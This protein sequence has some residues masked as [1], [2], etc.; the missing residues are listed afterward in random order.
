MEEKDLIEIEDHENKRS[1]HN[2]DNRRKFY[3]R[4]LLSAY[5][6]GKQGV[7][8]SHVPGMEDT[9]RLTAGELEA[10]YRFVYRLQGNQALLGSAQDSKH[11]EHTKSFPTTRNRRST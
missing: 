3:R 5:L 8:Y 4:D 9:R 6:T 7:T 10:K 11:M 1:Q 2:Q